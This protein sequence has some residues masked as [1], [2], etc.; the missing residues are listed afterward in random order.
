MPHKHEAPEP[1]VVED[2]AA[3]EE[4][5]G[6]GVAWSAL[7]AGV[8]R[9]SQFGMSIIIA[10]V[11]APREFGVFVVALTVYA[12]IVNVSEVGVGSALLREVDRAREI[13]PTIST[14]AI[15]TSAL[16]AGRMV[17]TAPWFASALGST[18]ATNSVRVMALT[19]VIGGA[20]GIAHPGLSTRTSLH[21]RC[22]RIRHI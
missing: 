1:P 5:V 10:R 22:R 16:L 11:V 14:I 2:G 21:R 18:A 3:L 19:V 15:T 17:A 8:L 4:R 7:N 6:R 13:A 12:I 20:G 9:L